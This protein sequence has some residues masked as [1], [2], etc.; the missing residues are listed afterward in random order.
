MFILILS[1]FVWIQQLMKVRPRQK[2]K[3]LLLRA[4]V[5]LIRGGVGMFE[6]DPLESLMDLNSLRISDSCLS[7]PWLSIGVSNFE[8]L[9]VLEVTVDVLRPRDQKM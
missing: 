9:M 4:Y 7:W 5:H 1:G 2:T 6:L 8:K 3:K